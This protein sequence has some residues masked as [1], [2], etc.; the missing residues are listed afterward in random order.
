MSSAARYLSDAN[1]DFCGVNGILGNFVGILCYVTGRIT[2]L[3]SHFAGCLE[4]FNVLCLYE[5]LF[6]QWKLMEIGNRIFGYPG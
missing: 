4:M 6:T 3:T 5:R 2:S 1:A